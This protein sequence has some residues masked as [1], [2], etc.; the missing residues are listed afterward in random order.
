MK[1]HLAIGFL[2]LFSMLSYAA[3]CNDIDIRLDDVSIEESTTDYFDFTI[4][5]ESD[6][7]FDIT[8]IDAGDSSSKFTVT[9]SDYDNTIRDNDEGDLEIKI[10]AFSVSST[11]GSEGFVKVRGRFD[12]DKYCSFSAIGTEYFDV[13]VE[14]ESNQCSDIEV[15][16]SNVTMDEEDVVFED[17]RIENN[18]NK[19]FY[20]D[21]IGIVESSSLLDVDVD[22]HDSSI[23]A[24]DEGELTLRLESEE[25]SS[26]RTVSVKVKVKGHFQSGSSCSFSATEED[27]FTVRIEDGT[28]GEF[29]GGGECR[30]LDIGISNLE[31]E[32]GDTVTKNFVLENNSHERFYV[33]FVD[34]YDRSSEIRSESNGYDKKI[35]AKAVGTIGVKVRAYE[36]AEIDDYKAYI[37]VR[38]HFQGGDSCRLSGNEEDFKVE[39]VE[40]EEE[41]EFVVPALPRYSDYCRGLIFSAPATKTIQQGSTISL[42]IENN[43][44]YRATIRFK[45]EGLEVEPSLLSI[46]AGFKKDNYTISVFANN[47]PTTLNYEIETYNCMTKKSTRIVSTTVQAPVDDEEEEE[48][49]EPE[50]EE[51]EDVLQ[52]I[53]GT[54]FAVLGANSVNAGLLLVAA[55]ALI[56]AFYVASKQPKTKKQTFLK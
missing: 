24:D 25:V 21:D 18:S 10:R 52:A 53:A 11:H 47:T 42:N 12:D 44:A 20:V 8:E 33:D 31:V 38:G 4:E 14:N 40:E 22:D 5:N 39:V 55:V 29:V 43:T 17:I 6:E 41:T 54:A 15:V 36:D 56:Y 50:E 37:A 35:L 49:V 9:V 48:S 1:F 26:D 27:S 3:S 16:A 23:P 45:G 7:D 28:S 51:Q 46:P 30:D 13:T 32:R 2:L 34:V 19:R